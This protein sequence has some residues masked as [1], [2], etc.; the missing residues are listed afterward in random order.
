[1]EIV[2]AIQ[3]MANLIFAELLA[4]ATAEVS[5]EEIAEPQN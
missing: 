3:F 1:L 2:G 5:E 4:E